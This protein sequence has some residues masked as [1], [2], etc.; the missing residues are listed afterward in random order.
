MILTTIGM[1]EA[2]FSVNVAKANIK[3]SL[4]L[5]YNSDESYFY[6]NKKDICRFKAHDNI[7]WYEFCSASVLK[8]F[9]KDFSLN[10]TVYDFSVDYSAIENEDILN[11]HKNIEI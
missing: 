5:H 4:S 2:K 11:F 1:A 8:D 7:P 10:C 6:V 3:F 9:A